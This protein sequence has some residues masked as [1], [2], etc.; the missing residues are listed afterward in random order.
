MKSI[1]F[2]HSSD[3][4]GHSS[5]A[6]VNLFYR[7]KYCTEPF[8]AGINYG[9]DLPERTEDFD[10]CIIVDF[11]FNRKDMIHLHKIFGEKLVWI[12]HHDSSI[13]EMWDYQ[14]KIRGLRNKQS[15]ACQLAWEF[16]FGDNEPRSITLL[17]NYDIWNHKD[18]DVLP[19]QYGIR[20]HSTWPIK[21]N[22]INLWSPLFLNRKQVLFNDILKEGHTIFDY[23]TNQNEIIS[24]AI[25]FDLDFEKYKFCCGNVPLKNS[26]V[27]DSIID[28]E[29]HDAIMLFSYMGKYKQWKVGMYTEK[30]NVVLN[31]IAEKYGGGGHQ[32]ACGFVCDWEN[33]PKELKEKIRG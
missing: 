32:K 17:G 16:Y 9:E 20:N 1:C 25:S 19:F 30:E 28:W 12:D 15:A 21:D 26:K 7:K 13:N 8:M 23:E 18:P 6:I 5:G 33:L 10:E 24:K 27:M 22:I 14:D 31:K 4:D 11:S 2:F 3:M 29:E